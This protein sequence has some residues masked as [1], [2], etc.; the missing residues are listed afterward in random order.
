MTIYDSLIAKAIGGSGGGGGGGSSDFSTATLTLTVTGGEGYMAALVRGFT[1]NGVSYQNEDVS[2]SN[3]IQIDLYNGTAYI[4]IY[5]DGGA[6]ITNITG[7]FTL[8]EGSSNS[9]TMTGNCSM[10]IL[11][12]MDI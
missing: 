6:P 12:Y 5:G 9:G 3:E 1:V 10:S 11:G 7:D 8:D 2:L 4:G